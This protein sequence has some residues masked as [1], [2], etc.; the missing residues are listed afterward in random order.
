MMT[1]DY[2]EQTV[3]AEE[4]LGGLERRDCSIIFEWLREHLPVGQVKIDWSSVQGRHVNWRFD[5]DAQLKA[6]AV[7][8]VCK[9]IRPGSSVEHAGDG[10]SAV[11]VRF[12]EG[13]AAAVVGALLEIPE[14]HYFLAGDRS[15][16][17]VVT[18]EG[19]LDILDC[20]VEDAA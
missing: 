16:L 4:P 11:G 12:G 18:T 3:Y 5:D 8:E 9:R 7:Q 19:D 15:W 6:L 14:H 10:L 17:V 2:W 1:G 13:E 20:P